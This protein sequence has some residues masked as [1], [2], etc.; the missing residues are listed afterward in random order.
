MTGMSWWLACTDKVCMTPSHSN[1]LTITRKPSV[2]SKSAS[3]P[4]PRPPSLFLHKFPCHYLVWQQY[5]SRY[6][7]RFQLPPAVLPFHTQQY[8]S[9]DTRKKVQSCFIHWSHLFCF[10]GKLNLISLS[11]CLKYLCS[12]PYNYLGWVTM[13][14]GVPHTETHSLT[15]RNYGNSG[16]HRNYFA[17]Y[18]IKLKN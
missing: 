16:L 14:N 18:S 2:K 6:P 17:S 11:E 12:L 1:H 7:F 5:F 4:H 13:I 8:S 10:D 15:L 3:L 9:S